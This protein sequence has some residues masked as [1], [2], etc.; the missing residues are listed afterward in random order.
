MVFG[1]FVADSLSLTQAVC[2]EAGCG[3]IFDSL[4]SLRTHAKVA[5]CSAFCE[6]CGVPMLKKSLVAHAR[7]HGGQ[8]LMRCPHAGCLHSYNKVQLCDQAHLGICST[9]GFLTTIQ[10]GYLLGQM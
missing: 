1:V 4:S 5:H 3:E 9:C 10:Y 2:M 7:K 6:T 8:A